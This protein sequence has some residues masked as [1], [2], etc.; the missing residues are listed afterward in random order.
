MTPTKWTACA[1]EGPHARSKPHKPGKGFP[2][3]VDVGRTT[4]LSSPLTLP[5]LKCGRVGGWERAA[6][7]K[8]GVRVKCSQRPTLTHACPRKRPSPSLE[9]NLFE[10]AR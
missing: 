2:P 10:V 1:V 5:L 7:K 9:P 8:A 6:E 4:A 3:P